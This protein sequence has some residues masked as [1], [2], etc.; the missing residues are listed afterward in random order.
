M[1][2]ALEEIERRRQELGITQVRLCAAAEINMTYYSG[3]LLRGNRE[4]RASTIARLRK[5]LNDLARRGSPTTPEFSLTAS[6]RL[7]MVVAAHALGADPAK[8][9]A[10]D[11][12]RRA[13]QDPEW[14]KAAEVRRLA[15]YLLTSECGFRQVDVARAAGM[16]RQAVHEAVKELEDQRDEGS[17][18]EAMVDELRE[19]IMGDAYEPA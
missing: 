9:Q 4:P 3:F 14:M 16:T 11:P 10:S 6:F 2:P 18:F 12:A 13:T 15:L 19:W 7:A 1:S 17:A 5:A 8:A